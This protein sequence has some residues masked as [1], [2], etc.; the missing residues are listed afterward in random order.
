MRSRQE[1]LRT[2]DEATKSFTKGVR[3]RVSRPEYAKEGNRLGTNSRATRMKKTGVLSDRDKGSS[4]SWPALMKINPTSSVR[5]FAQT[6]DRGR[7]RML[8]VGGGLF[9]VP[10][11][12]CRLRRSSPRLRSPSSRR[13]TNKH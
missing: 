4:E 6:Q 7:G 9:L 1:S 3:Q 8:P 12:S 11:Y 2:P 10:L 13:V 5:L